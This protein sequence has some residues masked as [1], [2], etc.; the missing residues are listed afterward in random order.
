MR[1]GGNCAFYVLL[2][3]AGLMFRQLCPVV[4][5]CSSCH[6]GLETTGIRKKGHSLVDKCVSC[7][8]LL[9][10]Q[11]VFDKSLQ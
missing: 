8:V 2:F 5:A 10:S 9:L 11:L 3:A 1:H 7:I 4:H 6:Y